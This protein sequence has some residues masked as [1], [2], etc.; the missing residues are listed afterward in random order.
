MIEALAPNGNMRLGF[1]VNLL[2][3]PLETLSS[4]ANH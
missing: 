3:T 2:K 4:E 1:L